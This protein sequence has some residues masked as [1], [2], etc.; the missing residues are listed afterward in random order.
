MGIFWFALA[1]ILFGSFVEDHGG[2]GSQATA[3]LFYGCGIIFA[4]G[5][6]KLFGTA[7]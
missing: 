3:H 2:P 4:I 7:L 1:L 5:W 6:H